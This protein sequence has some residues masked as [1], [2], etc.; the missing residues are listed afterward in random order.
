MKRR[1]PFLRPVHAVLRHLP[2]LALAA[3]GGC[4][5]LPAADPGP[6]GLSRD[7]PA[8][9]LLLVGEEH[10]AAEHQRR[11]AELVERLAGQK[12]LIAVVMEMAELG[13]STASLPRDASEE[14]MRE[15]L[16]WDE[17]GWPWAAYAPIVVAAVRAGVPVVGGNLAPGALRSAMQDAT[18]DAQV[19]DAVRARLLDDVRDGHCGLLPEAKL[20]AMTRAQ[21]AR[22]RAMAETLRSLAQPGGVVM[23]VAGANHVDATRGVPQ[24]LQS[25]APE[26]RLHIVRLHAGTTTSAGFDTTWLTPPL[27]R[28]DPCEG[29]AERFGPAR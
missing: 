13:G 1:R 11:A 3:A 14:R 23:L 26:L 17:R 2:W 10:D 6:A 25:L 15:V 24:H 18:L 29:L 12:R 7:W 19:S 9:E 4:T 8:A 22:D 16:A 21:I 28:P 5:G 27:E 20:P